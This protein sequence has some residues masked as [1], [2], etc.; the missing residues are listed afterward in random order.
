[1][2]KRKVSSPSP[3]SPMTIVEK[4]IRVLKSRGYTQDTYEQHMK[5]ARGRFSKWLNGQGQPSAVDA[6][7]IAKDLGVDVTYF[8]DPEAGEPTLRV[9]DECELPIRLVRHLGAKEAM[10]RL[11]LE[12]R[13]DRGEG[14]NGRRR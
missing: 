12:D 10:L 1:M 7:R 11:T 4:M 13:E 3:V 5:L 8:L 6:W 9:E 2:G 14:G